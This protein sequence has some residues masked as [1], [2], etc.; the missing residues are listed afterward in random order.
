VTIFLSMWVF[1][2]YTIRIVIITA[3]H[4]SQQTFITSKPL[5]ITLIPPSGCGFFMYGLI[6]AFFA[7]IFFAYNADR[8]IS[9][10]F[11]A[12]GIITSILSL[13]SEKSFTFNKTTREVIYNSRTFYSSK[14]QK[15]H[16]SEITD[17]RVEQFDS[18]DDNYITLIM[19]NNGKVESL[20]CMPN[21]FEDNLKL[22]NRVREY[23]GFNLLDL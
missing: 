8:L 1:Y 4:R 9:G 7:G 19:F 10:S 15:Y 14:Y 11:I 12:L 18:F 2:V 5:L 3:M 16:F 23:I 17:I 22:A 20:S 13:F 6:I 21:S